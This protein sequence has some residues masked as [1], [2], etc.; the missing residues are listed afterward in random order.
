MKLSS[1]GWLISALRDPS[2]MMLLLCSHRCIPSR[3]S[4]P[5]LPR[6]L[7]GTV[8]RS[9]VHIKPDQS[10]VLLKALVTIRASC[11][12]LQLEELCAFWTVISSYPQTNPRMQQRVMISL[13]TLQVGRLRSTEMT[14]L[15]QGVR[16]AWERNLKGTQSP[17]YGVA[18]ATLVGR[19]ELLRP[20][21]SC[22]RSL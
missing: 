1:G 7:Q 4:H 9:W 18:P 20:R 19:G 5:T 22:N 8:L 11:G 21:M 3:A 14:G 13:P 6:I 10:A 12:V 15:G 2:P 16:T 17:L